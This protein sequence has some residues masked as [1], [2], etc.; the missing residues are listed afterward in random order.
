MQ[1]IIDT[2]GEKMSQYNFLNGKAVRFLSIVGLLLMG[3]MH[4]ENEIG[5]SDSYLQIGGNYTYANIDVGGQPSFHGNLGGAQGIYEYQPS[6]SI[7]G[8]LRLAWKQGKTE[9]SFANREL[10]YVDAQGRVGYTYASCCNDWL[11]TAFSG[12]G[13]RY[14]GH[15]LKQSEVPSVKFEYN[16][17]Y[18][19]VGLLSE[20]FLCSCWS[21]GLNSIWMPQVFPTVE[22]I[23][24]K[25][26]YWSLKN[27]I[28][29]VLVELP[30]T[31]YFTEDKCYSLVFKPFY[32]HWENGRSTAKTSGGE[33]LGLPKNFYNFWGAELNIAFSF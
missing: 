2:I 26:T 14:L 25:G 9:N 11:L 20:Y 17:F 29:N 8:G 10:I 5:T 4:A 24:F 31:Y 13:Y 6:N 30:L 22:I 21:I 12:V 3:T 27:T 23:P 1:I 28:G 18:V 15:K 32:E 16:E 33:E 7:Y 19:P